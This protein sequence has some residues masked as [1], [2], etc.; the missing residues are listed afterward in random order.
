MK[1]F[2]PALQVA[3]FAE[4]SLSPKLVDSIV[5]AQFSKPTSVQSEAIP[6]ALTGA[7][8]IAVAQT[9]SGKTMAYALS[10]MTR[11]EANP[12]AR[13][14]VLC[15]SRETAEQVHRVMASLVEDLPQSL[16]LAVAG[17]PEKIQ[18][19]QFKKSPRIVVATPGR[20]KEMLEKNKLL[21]QGLQILVIDEADRML[22]MGFEPQLKFIKST[23]RG[24]WQTMMFAATFGEWA[25]PVAELFM[26]TEPTLIRSE[27]AEKPVST[28]KQ[29][30]YF[31]M[32]AQKN[33][34]L[35][36]ELKSM[37]SGVIIFAD[38]QDNC[39]S[40]GRLLDHHEFSS[41]FVH[42][43]MNPGHRNRILREFREG[44]TQILVTTDLLARGIDVPHVKHVLSYD[45][46]YKSEDFLH[47]IGRTARAGA[48]GTAITFVTPGDGRTYRKLKGYLEGAEVEELV[49]DFRFNEQESLSEQ[50][51]GKSQPAADRSKSESAPPSRRSKSFKARKK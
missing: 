9:G 25:K 37:K 14:L 29:K 42:G 12:E 3:E 43:D 50:R 18:L 8:F 19:N 24:S 22:S 30:V 28:L 45:L 16:A 47:R 1:S 48:T 17:I 26:K 6:L 13:A 11:L 20:L 34:R 49:K 33:N 38:S 7:D 40:I 44:Q 15:P 31:M 51:P 23:L 5:K 39:V 4:M 10:L 32:W 36:D 27:R 41:D 21:L 35:L 2:D 46:P